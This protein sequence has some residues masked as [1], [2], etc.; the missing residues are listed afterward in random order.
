[1]KR[2]RIMAAVL[3]II[4]V[5]TLFS[6]MA[7]ATWGTVS[8]WTTSY[9]NNTFLYKKYHASAT[10]T[11]AQC[12]ILAAG[13]KYPAGNITYGVGAM[14]FAQG[15]YAHVTSLEESYYTSCTGTKIAT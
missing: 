4:V 6:T 5:L 9:Y 15:V 12:S 2:R 10:T 14:Y 7:M 3:S 1:M 8:T 13:W 11:T